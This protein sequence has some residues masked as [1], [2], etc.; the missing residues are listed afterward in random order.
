MNT[1]SLPVGVIEGME[2]ALRSLMPE[3]PAG[4]LNKAVE[5]ALAPA[6]PSARMETV[7]A[8]E[9]RAFLGVSSMT[10]WR[11]I[12][13]GR[14]PV[15]QISNR[16]VCFLRSEL[17]AYISDSVRKRRGRPRGKKNPVI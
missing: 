16:R 1:A 3:L 11:L 4:F 10:L 15:H 13:A 12:R 6:A 2:L 14:I 7:S 8:A 5:A 17:E 9:A